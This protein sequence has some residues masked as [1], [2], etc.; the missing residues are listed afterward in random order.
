[1]TRTYFVN[2]RYPRCSKVD[3]IWCSRKDTLP[4]LKMLFAGERF[5]WTPTKSKSLYW[6]GYQP[7]AKLLIAGAKFMNTGVCKGLDARSWKDLYQIAMCESDVNK[8]PERIAEAEGAIV[9][10]A[11][12]LFYTSG[13]SSEEQESLDDAMCI[14]H[15]L[16]SSL[17]HRPTAVPAT[18]RVHQSMLSAG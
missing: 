9:L 12:Q 3:R 11:R 6:Y 1:M 8:L 2:A 17:K 16:R 5:S 7:T 14:L 10:R 4:S 15:A 18:N 13:D